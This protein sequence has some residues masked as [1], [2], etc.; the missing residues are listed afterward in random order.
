ML[1]GGGQKYTR[2]ILWGRDSI[3]WIMEYLWLYF[4]LSLVPRLYFN[5]K[6]E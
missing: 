4:A 1:N 6:A 2:R 5:T 3:S